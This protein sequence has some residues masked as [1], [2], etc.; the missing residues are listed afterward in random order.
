MLG[1]V[2]AQ[3]CLLETRHVRRHLVTKNSFYE[4]LADYYDRP[5]VARGRTGAASLP[6]APIPAGA[7]GATPPL[8]RCSRPL[9]HRRRPGRR[10]PSCEV[11]VRTRRDRRRSDGGLWWLNRTRRTALR[12]SVVSR[13]HSY[14]TTDPLAQQSGSAD[15]VTSNAPDLDSHPHPAP[16]AVRGWHL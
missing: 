3:G 14:P 11:S 1:R 10:R 8:R 7:A 6:R 12:Y 2:D 13:T 9:A 4:R 5:Q 15:Q 16:W